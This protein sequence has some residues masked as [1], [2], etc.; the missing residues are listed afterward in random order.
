MNGAGAEL[1]QFREMQQ[2]AVAL[3]LAEAILREARAKFAHHA[4]ARHFRDHARGGDAQAV[5]IAVHDCG[6]R[7]RKGKDR[8]AIDERVFGRRGERGD[9]GAHRLVGG[10]QNIDAIDLE[11]IDDADG[12][13]DLELSVVSSA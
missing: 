9:G 5:A 2:R 12:P 6:L 1:L 13:R 8:K 7:E 4:V 10:A 11:R 3:V